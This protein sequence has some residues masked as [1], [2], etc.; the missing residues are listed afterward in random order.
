MSPEQVVFA[1]AG[2]ACIVGSVIAV[3]HRDPRAAGAA[4]LVTLLS[5]ATMYAV[6][7]APAVAAIAI[8]VTLLAT[9]PFIVYLTVPAARAAGGG[10]PA[11]AGAAILIG[12]ALFAIVAVAVWLGELPLNVSVRS[13]TG[14]DVDG[15]RDLLAGRAAIAAAGSVVVLLAA[16]AG[17]RAAMRR[18]RIER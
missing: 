14:Y 18:E 2:A 8:G 4:L 11:V 16:A 12:A 15:L 9:A 6:L 1:L 13:S 5:L 3:T 10:A 7:A 17:A